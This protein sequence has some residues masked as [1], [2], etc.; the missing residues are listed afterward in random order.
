MRHLA[1]FLL[2]SEAKTLISQTSLQRQPTICHWA[3]WFLCFFTF[4]RAGFSRKTSRGLAKGSDSYLTNSLSGHNLPPSQSPLL[5]DWQR[6][7][8][9]G[10]LDNRRQWLKWTQSILMKLP[11]PQK[12]QSQW[13]PYPLQVASSDFQTDIHSHFPQKQNLK[14]RLLISAC[15]ANSAKIPW[16]VGKPYVSENYFFRFDS[17]PQFIRTHQVSATV[18]WR[19]WPFWAT[20]HS[21]SGWLQDRSSNLL[22]HGLIRKK[23]SKLAQRLY[24]PIEVLFQLSRLLKGPF[25]F[26]KINI[27]SVAQSGP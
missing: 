19:L 13:Y 17:I 24:P 22:G 9:I 27:Y 12:L 7:D 15:L 21:A 14:I 20:T 6:T 3:F 18:H 1:I 11:H 10:I 2:S 5:S 26:L 8:F 25:S 4:G 23:S 16:V